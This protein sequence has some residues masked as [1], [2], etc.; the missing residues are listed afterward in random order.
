MMK[1]RLL[2]I[3]GGALTINILLFILM[4]SMSAPKEI[5]LT[6]PAS[7]LSIDFVRLKKTPP[8]AQIKT[9]NKPKKKLKKPDNLMLPD[10]PTPSSNSV[11]VKNIAI[12]IP[13]MD[14]A[15]NISGVPFRGQLANS[16]LGGLSEAIPLIRTSPLYPPRALSRKIEGKV[17]VLFTITKEGTVID[18][19]V[20]QATPKQTFNRAA[21]RAIRKWKFKKKLVD[22]AAV[23]WQSV[24]TITFKLAK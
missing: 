14:L 12:K 10:I 1:A 2:F 7:K 24:Q 5:K 6:A 17:K 15:I 23:S 18:P 22:G 9:R 16:G 11:H 20:I 21:L 4:E 8:P 3:G 19:K 13:K